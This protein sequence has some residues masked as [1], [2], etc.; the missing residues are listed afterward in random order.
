MTATFEVGQ[1]FMVGFDGYELPDDVERLLTTRDIAGVVLFR[2]NIESAQQLLALTTKI[3]ARARR[4]IL[5][6]VDHEGGRVFRMPQPFT[7]VPPLAQ[8]ADV[9][10]SAG[11]DMLIEDLGYMMGRELAACGINCNFAPVLDINTRQKN[12]IIGDRAF[13][14]NAAEVARM[15]CAYVQGL[16]RASMIACGKHFPGHGDTAEDSHVGV[17]TV[18]HTF[19]R[20]EWM[21]LVPFARA[22]AAQIPMLMTAHVVYAGVDA[23][24]PATLSRLWIHEIL[25][26]QMGYQGVIVTDDLE[27]GA[28]H[29][30]TNPV[31]AAYHALAAGCDLALVCHSPALAE[32]GMERVKQALADG[33]ISR[34]QLEASAERLRELKLRAVPPVVDLNAIGSAE[35][36]GIAA[37]FT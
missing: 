37:R 28:I 13:A 35:H 5:I 17:P 8:V 33:D 34:A 24:W 27:M 36:Q 7:K 32:Q 21:E 26:G 15:A 4:P 14:N 19:A 12:P 25:R 22:I 16:R 3:R 6:A 23:V 10:R 18:P 30:F 20:M 9:A 1:L 31:D 2:R 29:E 11:S